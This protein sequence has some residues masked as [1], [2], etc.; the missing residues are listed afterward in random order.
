MFFLSSLKFYHICLYS[1]FLT[2]HVFYYLLGKR[3]E[4]VRVPKTCYIL[5]GDTE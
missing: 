1:F 4:I 5:T 3:F 2:V